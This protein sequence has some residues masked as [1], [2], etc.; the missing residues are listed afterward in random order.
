MIAGHL[1]NRPCDMAEKVGSPESSGNNL[2]LQATLVSI[3]NKYLQKIGIRIFLIDSGDRDDHSII[4]T[5]KVERHPYIAPL[6]HK[7]GQ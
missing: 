1:T 6:Q 3:F 4:V 2:E 7:I 5:G